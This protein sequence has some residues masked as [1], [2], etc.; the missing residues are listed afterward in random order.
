[1]N[2]KNFGYLGSSFQQSLLKTIIEDKKF[3]VTII[4]VIDSKYFDGPYFKYIM[5]NI[6]ELYTT[7]GSIPNYETLTQKILSEN[8][9]QS[10][11]IHIDTLNAIKEKELEDNGQ[12]V[13]KISLNF[14]RQQVLKKA[15][16]ESE[17]IMTNG[18][19]ENYD[20]IE[21]KIRG[22]LQVGT[23]VDDIEDIS[24]NIASSLEDDCRLPFPTGI[25]GIDNLLKG[26]IGR[27]EMAIFLAP[28]GIGKSLPISEPILTSN[29]W[30]AIGDIKVGDEIIGSNGKNQFVLGVYPQG[31]R[32]IYKIEFT[33][34]TFVN[35]D[36]E[37]LWSVNTLNMRTSKIRIK[38][39][40][41]YIPNN[42]R[43]VLKT[44]DMMKDIKKRGRYNYR[45]PIIKPVE[46][47]NKDISLDPYLLGIL[48]GDG[49]ISKNGIDITT[50]DD[51]IFENIK[52][53]ELHTSYKEYE[54]NNTQTIKRIH[55]KGIIKSKLEYYGLLGKKSNNKFI[56]KDYLYNSLETRIS[57]LQ[58]LMDTD[59]YVSKI[60]RV[61]FTT[62]SEQLS[63]DVRELVL[64]LG[65]TVRIHSK[66]P[67]YTYKGEKKNGQR[68]YS[69][70]ISF[71]NDIIPF[72][73][74]RK[75]TRYYKRKKYI[76]Q[77]YVKSITYSHN[78][79]AVCIKVSNSDELFVT[80]DFVLTHNTTWLTKMA[81]SAYGDGANVLQ[82]F[83]EDNLVDI[84]R[85]HYTI[86]TG[87]PPDKQPFNKE[88]VI[89]KVN[90]LTSRH[91]NFLK[92]AKY[93]SGTLTIND[94]K[95]KIRK[96]ESEGHKLDLL[97]LDYIDCVASVGA[98]S[99]EEWKGEG[100]IMR[101]LE[102]MTD[103]FNIAIWTATQGNRDS[104]SSD[105]V[106]TDQMGGSIKK[107]QI[108]HVVISA[109][110]TLEQKEHNLANL[111]LLKSRI[112]KDG[113]VFT[114]C[115]FDNEYLQIDTEAHNTLL[116]HEEERVELKK[117]RANQV[118]KESLEAKNKT[119]QIIEQEV[120]ILLE[121]KKTILNE[122]QDLEQKATILELTPPN[123]PIFTVEESDVNE[124][125][126]IV[127]FDKKE[128][129][130]TETI[131]IS[132]I[133]E[134]EK[135]RRRIAEVMKNRKK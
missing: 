64:S 131:Q 120:D 96:L 87:I 54:R 40:S 6:K 105:I 4:D 49:Y 61:Q 113:V 119:R 41:V 56:P 124:K 125:L 118:Y 21:N 28:T 7:F 99:G 133:S 22:A 14:C 32:P 51:E 57:L 58:G 76:E 2:E 81:N 10:S 111:T 116:G 48:L 13:K 74:I 91:S 47:E 42:G 122:L 12:Y 34:N 60:G 16:K 117:Q 109:A 79:E 37:H 94:I 36:E 132:E 104:I 110:K 53:L 82:I 65:G 72:K 92:L 129:K 78:E 127:D 8:K 103:E 18:D 108:G 62:I 69:L 107:A 3:A 128:E 100:T 9:E 88:E 84:R 123:D 70:T 101:N 98:L 75:V 126:T 67:S 45:L 89:E 121:K 17:E 33:D 5:E 86:W 135:N 68:T 25:E 43:K 71:A 115:K 38:G 55:L 15:L 30:V 26:G 112:G 77:K 35:C 31:V 20:K 73:L 50:K 90:T 134:A 19:F 44:S 46:F 24:E 106:T 27:G 29:G 95:N 59:G 23:I 83:F 52:K 102:S 11:K 114:N 85:K 97:V 63:K 39:N 130:Q 1:M 80:R 93:P 66:I